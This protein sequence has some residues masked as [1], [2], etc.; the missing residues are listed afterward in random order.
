MKIIRK[1]GLTPEFI[2]SEKTVLSK[3]EAIEIGGFGRPYQKD[4]IIKR[5]KSLFGRSTDC[6][7]D[8]VI[9]PCGSGKSLLIVYSAILESIRNNFQKARLIL[10]PTLALAKNV[11]TLSDSNRIKLHNTGEIITY[12]AGLSLSSVHSAGKKA[13]EL[14]SWI[15]K[16]ESKKSSEKYTF[17]KTLGSNY[18]VVCYATFV[19]FVKK[20]LEKEDPINFYRWLAFNFDIS[21]D[22]MH[23]LCME[24]SNSN[25]LGSI[26]DKFDEAGG[27]ATGFTATFI[28]SEFP[29]FNEK[30]RNKCL[31]NTIPTYDYMVTTGIEK[32]NYS[33][34]LYCNKNN[35]DTKIFAHLSEKSDCNNMIIMAPAS[36]KYYDSK[37][38]KKKHMENFQAQAV[39]AQG[40]SIEQ[41]IDLIT[42]N[43]QK[44]NS[45]LLQKHG[46]L[47]HARQLLVCNMGK[48]GLDWPQCSDVIDTQGFT[49]SIGTFIQKSMRNCRRFPGKTEV[50]NLVFLPS[51]PEFHT[52]EGSED[53]KIWIRRFLILVSVVNCQSQEM[54]RFRVPKV[55]GGEKTPLP[56][57]T[58]ILGLENYQKVALELSSAVEAEMLGRTS[59]LE[60]DALVEFI[61]SKSD[62]IL[63][64]YKDAIEESAVEFSKAVKMLALEEIKSLGLR[65][66]D[67]H[68]TRPLPDL[69]N[70]DWCEKWLLAEEPEFVEL[71]TEIRE[72]GG[73]F[74][75]KMIAT[76]GPEIYKKISDHVRE[77][78]DFCR[79]LYTGHLDSAVRIVLACF[80]NMAEKKA[81]SEPVVLECLREISRK[82]PEGEDDVSI[83]KHIVETTLKKY[84][85]LK[86]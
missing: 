15:R 36:Q 70:L 56:T 72:A 54:V 12:E 40:I 83:L 22:E 19:N 8:V 75:S 24:E 17:N 7:F 16:L 55:P 21:I 23:H 38:D 69:D 65:K 85:L 76:I 4:L 35:L 27:F 52:P 48:E 51:V 67:H 60:A 41:S 81:K 57:L 50:S 34:E 2:P 73:Y 9:G 64:P 1:I 80:N 66:K 84:K 11:T 59:E 29:I 49:E 43:G 26:I 79:E 20:R 61:M 45:A 33:V 32:I 14:D 77:Q 82:I 42:P 58:E 44:S 47:D 6:N 68:N 71:V 39:S 5:E 74:V 53:L 37:A 62:T 13:Q 18:A 28:R 78:K 3:G 63:F 25:H 30:L 46:G 31:I 86:K 10:V